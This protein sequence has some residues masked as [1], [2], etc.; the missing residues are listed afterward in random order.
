VTPEGAYEKMDLQ[1]VS[2][3]D[4]KV[5]LFGTM[6]QTVIN[7]KQIQWKTVS[8]G[9]FSANTNA[10]MFGYQEAL[11]VSTYAFGTELP[12]DLT[13]AI[14]YYDYTNWNGTVSNN[15]LNDGVTATDYLRTNT[16]NVDNFR[17]L[18]IYPELV[19]YTGRTPITLWY[20][21]AKNL[22]DHTSDNPNAAGAFIHDADSGWGVGGKIGKAVKK[23]QWETYVSY[24]EVGANAVPAAFND[25]DFGGP[26]TKGYTNRKGYKFGIGY[27]LTDS[28]Q[29]YWTGYVVRPLD[30]TLLDA[31]STNETVFR[32]QLDAVY[33]F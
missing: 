20:D 6:A 17:V 32:S 27:N 4:T 28:L 5:N 33:K 14:S 30:V 19:F 9:V 7:D 26:G 23:G 10:D 29:L 3:E 25:S 22:G 8:G 13:G 21:Y 24:F 11:N 18:D 12:V 16:H 31:F 1:V 15:T 2:T